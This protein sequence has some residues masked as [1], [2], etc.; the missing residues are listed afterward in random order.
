MRRD[1]PEVGRIVKS[2][3]LIIGAPGVGKTTL[4]R[5]VVSTMR[6]RAGGFY[7]EDLQSGGSREGFR[8]VTLDGEM[9]LL[10]AT[11][12][13]GNMTVSK[14]GVDLQELERVAVPALQGAMRRGH[15]M[16][17]DEIGKMQLYSSAFRHTIL[18]A[19]RAGHPL[20]GTIMAGRNPYADRIKS[21]RN[22][23]ILELTESNRAEILATLR[24][25]FV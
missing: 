25:R 1:D 20:L 24:A 3:Y 8:I 11:G 23:E 9:G 7:T 12:R 17:A 21:Q 5:Q 19:V 10:A 18:D 15:V 22:V 14:Y 6:L 2:A 16:I 13:P 4:I